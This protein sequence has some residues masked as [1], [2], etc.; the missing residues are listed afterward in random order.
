MR[1]LT[2]F[3]ENTA[4]RPGTAARV[5]RQAVAFNRSQSQAVYWLAA[6]ADFGPASSQAL[7]AGVPVQGQL[8][9]RLSLAGPAT[10]PDQ[11]ALSNPGSATG[12]KQPRL[13]LAH[14]QHR[15]YLRDH[16]QAVY[17]EMEERWDL[18]P[19]DAP[20]ALLPNLPPLSLAEIIRDLAGWTTPPGDAFGGSKAEAV[21]KRG[22]RSSMKG[23]N[24]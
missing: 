1:Y 23:R 5:L 16:Q 19:M 8:T 4:P 10:G 21:P 11:S 6:M 3:F 17:E 13:T 12:P 2:Y 14:E 18:A 9:Y 22:S 20:A 15:N 7:P 24:D